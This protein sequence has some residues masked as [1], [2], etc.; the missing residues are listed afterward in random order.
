MPTAVERIIWGSGDGSTLPVFD[1]P[2]G[3]AGAAI[4]WENYMPLLRAAMYAK[5]IQLYCAPP[6]MAPALPG[7]EGL[8][9][10]ADA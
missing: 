9:T 7:Q 4:C 10:E 5:G 2:G 3:K 8:D 6:S 1:T